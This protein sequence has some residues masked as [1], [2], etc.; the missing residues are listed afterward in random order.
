[1]LSYM[2]IKLS[3]SSVFPILFFLVERGVLCYNVKLNTT[4]FF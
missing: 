4:E 2:H 3:Q 1:M